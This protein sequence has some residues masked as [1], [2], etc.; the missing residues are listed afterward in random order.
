MNKELTEKQIQILAH[1]LGWDK[2]RWYD[3]KKIGVTP[4]RN[5]F[6]TNPST[7]DYAVIQSLI[8][9]N[10]MKALGRVYSESSG[11]CFSV[12][13]KGL[14][15]AYY[16]VKNQLKNKKPT[17]SKRRYECY[18]HCEADDETFIEWLTNPYWNDCRKRYSC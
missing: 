15:F 12:T 13:E 2:L 10:L 17:R 14:C 16:Y 5:Y 9:M 18:L 8:A 3:I 1:S 6:F 11:I 4:Y 7:S